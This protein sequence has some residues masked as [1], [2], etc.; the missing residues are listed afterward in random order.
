MSVFPP[1]GVVKVNDSRISSI[2]TKCS[3]VTR[4][5]TTLTI[6]KFYRSWRFTFGNGARLRE[7]NTS[8]ARCYLSALGHKMLSGAHRARARDSTPQNQQNR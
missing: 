1:S 2:M 5:V 3:R 4:E 8:P 6:A 7:S